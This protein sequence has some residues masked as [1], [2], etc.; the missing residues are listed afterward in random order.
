MTRAQLT[1][2][3]DKVQWVGSNALEQAQIFN[4]APQFGIAEVMYKQ[5]SDYTIVLGTKHEFVG[6]HKAKHVG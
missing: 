1:E 4:S 2:M 6:K 5:V 3:I